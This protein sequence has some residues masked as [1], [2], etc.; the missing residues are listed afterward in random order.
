[1]TFVVNQHLNRLVL[2]ERFFILKEPESSSEISISVL[3]TIARTS[4]SVRVV[5]LHIRLI[6]SR[7][8][9]I[10]HAKILPKAK[11]F[12]LG[13]RPPISTLCYS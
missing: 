2:S 6:I 4:I 13:H 1:M 10:P 8:I 9:Q 3:E 12:R 5:H 7:L 11:A